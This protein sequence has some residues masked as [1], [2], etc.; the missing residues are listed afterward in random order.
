MNYAPIARIILRYI[1]GGVI[2][3]SQ[4][5]GDTLAADPDLVTAIAAAVGAG[6][7]LAYAMAKR[8]GWSL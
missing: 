5:A 3:G 7:E 6:V 1:I 8:N 4:A 2:V